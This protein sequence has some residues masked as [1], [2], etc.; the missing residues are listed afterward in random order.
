MYEFNQ[1]VEDEKSPATTS[2]KHKFESV[3]GETNP[4]DCQNQNNK[5]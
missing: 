3:F 1:Q 4:L 2:D 5:R